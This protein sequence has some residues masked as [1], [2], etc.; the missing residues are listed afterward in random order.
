VAPVSPPPVVT[1]NA[2]SAATNIA[3]LPAPKPPPPAFKLQS[4]F[5][6]PRNP[7]VVIN[8]K[9]LFIGD[10]VGEARVI[11]IRQDSATIVTSAGKTNLLELP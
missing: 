5:Y 10:R 1:S 6:S 11:S 4:I 7:S 9:I 2:S 3:E 8:G